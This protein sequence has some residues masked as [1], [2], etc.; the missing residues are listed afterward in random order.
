MTFGETEEEQG[1]DGKGAEGLLGESNLF[2]QGV[3]SHAVG[4][5]DMALA[6]VVLPRAEKEEAAFGTGI[7]E[8]VGRLVIVAE[9]VVEQTDEGMALFQQHLHNLLFLGRDERGD[10]HHALPGEEDA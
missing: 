7:E 8:G 10:H 3:E 5:A 2:R 6:G 1:R 9:A 4:A